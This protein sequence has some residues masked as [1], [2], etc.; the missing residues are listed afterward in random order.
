[1]RIKCCDDQIIVAH[2]KEPING[3]EEGLIVQIE[4]TVRSRTA[5]DCN[6]FIV[7][8]DLN[9]DFEMGLYNET[10]KTLAEL[11]E[12]NS[13]LVTNLEDHWGANNE[14]EVNLV[15]GSEESGKQNGKSDSQG[16]HEE[17]FL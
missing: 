9:K 10:I 2:L 13:Y 7:L 14:K 4:A 3:I 8:Q 17:S 12:D 6:D 15:D 5:L 1:M 16:A 11:E